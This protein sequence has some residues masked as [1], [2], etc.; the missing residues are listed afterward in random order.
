MAAIGI[1]P[2]RIG[3][4]EVKKKNIRPLCGKP[5]MYY[6]IIEA[7]RSKK[8]QRVI[9]ST[10]S[11]EIRTIGKELGIE[12]PFLRPAVLS[13]D[14]ASLFDVVIHCLEVLAEHD[15][16]HP[17]AVFLLRPTSPFRTAE[18][19]DEA[20]AMLE[21]KGVDSITAMEQVKQHPYFMFR[22][23]SG[24]RLVEYDKT[25]NKPERRQDLPL[26]WKVNC[27]TMLS[28]TAYLE[29][30]NE[31]G[32]KNIINFKNF[33]PYCIEGASAIDIDSEQDFQFAE[34]MMEHTQK[35]NNE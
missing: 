8:L 23:D 18:Q 20:I 1:I 34:F 10:D 29:R 30:E 3:S 19:I 27:H 17:D 28:T 35:E 15:N 24:G 33:A 21:W 7:R 12:A 32:G 4:S 14:V 2:A 22:R 13:G 6:S 16:Y 26:I 11:E 31:K 5:L 25:E 9:L